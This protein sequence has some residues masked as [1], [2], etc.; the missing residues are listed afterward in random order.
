LIGGESL[1]VRLRLERQ[2]RHV[3]AAE[4]QAVHRRLT[5]VGFRR[6]AAR[7]Q[8]ERA[9]RA[10]LRLTQECVDA[11]I[12]GHRR[13]PRVVRQRDAHLTLAACEH[14]GT[15]L[16]DAAACNPLFPD[17]IREPA[18]EVAHSLPVRRH[19]RRFTLQLGLMLL[20]P[21]RDMPGVGMRRQLTV[22]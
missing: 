9:E 18:G 17:Q 21:R 3:V 7:L 6:G 14:D 20:Q 12:H 22:P 11:A 15:R 1:L 5:D 8:L 10:G 19:G 13:R 4:E 2:Q 16:G